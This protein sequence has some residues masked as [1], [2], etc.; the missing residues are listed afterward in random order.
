M[1]GFLPHFLNQP[2]CNLINSAAFEA[3]LLLLERFVF[4]DFFSFSCHSPKRLSRSF[5]DCHQPAFTS[6]T[7]ALQSFPWMWLRFEWRDAWDVSA[8]NG[9][10][11]GWKW[12]CV[13]A[14]APV[15]L[16]IRAV[17]LF[18]SPGPLSSK[19]LCHLSLCCLP[20][21]CAH[22]HTWRNASHWILIMVLVIFLGNYLP[23][24]PLIVLTVK[25]GRVAHRPPSTLFFLISRNLIRL[26][27]V[28]TLARTNLDRLL[29]F[30]IPRTPS[31]LSLSKPTEGCHRSSWGFD[32]HR[33]TSCSTCFIRRLE[34]DGWVIRLI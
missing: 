4:N 14:R 30:F 11:E 20:K 16:L 33:F 6:L 26:L 8:S 15:Y 28:V 29:F 34:E 2:F 22:K 18:A 32:T 1:H 21:P 12:R 17:T 3:A 10:S 5:S 25:P 27:V 24:L 19:R 7:A 13:L 9:Q 31:L 23:R